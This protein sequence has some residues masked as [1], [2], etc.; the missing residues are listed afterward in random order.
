[1]PEEHDNKFEKYASILNDVGEEGVP[2]AERKGVNSKAYFKFKEL[3]KD[4][5]EDSDS[6]NL[7]LDGLDM[8]FSSDEESGEASEKKEEDTSSSEETEETQ[9]DSDD[10][11]TQTEQDIA[12]LLELPVVKVPTETEDY[13]YDGP[14]IKEVDDKI[15]NQLL[16]DLDQEIDWVDIQQEDRIL[17]NQTQDFLDDGEDI[18]NEYVMENYKE[19]DLKRPKIKERRK[20]IDINALLNDFEDLG[21]ETIDDDDEILDKVDFNENDFKDINLDDTDISDIVEIEE[22]D[23]EE[24]PAEE[25]I[26]E[27][28]VAEEPI[29]EEPVAEDIQLD[30]ISDDDS[31]SLDDISDDDSLSLDDISDDDSLSLDDI[32]DDDSLSL[33]DISDDDSLSLDDISD[34]DSLSLDDIS[35][36]DSLSLDDISD[37]DSLSLD[38]DDLITDDLDEITEDKTEDKTEEIFEDLDSDIELQDISDEIDIDTIDTDTTDTDSTDT[39][40]LEIDI[41][42]TPVTDM[43]DEDS[44]TPADVDADKE[45]EELFPEDE[46]PSLSEDALDSLSEQT[47]EAPEDEMPSLSEDALD[48]LSEQTDEESEDEMPSLSEDALDSLSEQTDEESE[49]EMPSLSEDAL[50]SLSEQT[51]EEPEISM[52]DISMDDISI[53]DDISDE[54]PEDE[55]PSLSEDALDSLSEQTDDTSDDE[56]SEFDLAAEEPTIEEPTI[57]EPSIEEPTIEEPTIEEPSIEEPTIEEPT[58]EEPSIEEP[59]IEEPIISEDD[60]TADLFGDPM[61]DNKEETPKEEDVSES[62]EEILTEEPIEESKDKSDE[63]DSLDDIFADEEP[64][65]DIDSEEEST[66]KDE[67]AAAS[68]SS[69]E[70]FQITE[71]SIQEKQE[72]FEMDIN[73]NISNE[74]EKENESEFQDFFDS[75]DKLSDVDDKK[76]TQEKIDIDTDIE[77][78]NET[79][80]LKLTDKQ[81]QKIVENTQKLPQ[82]LPKIIDK[83]DL[84]QN[85]LN[86]MLLLLLNDPNPQKI[87]DFI[88]KKTKQKIKLKEAPKKKSEKK[89]RGLAIHPALKVAS[90]LFLLVIIFILLYI[91]MIAP[92]MRADKKFEDAYAK[93]TEPNPN[94]I[95]NKTDDVYTYLE[96]ALQEYPRINLGD[97]IYYQKAIAKK[98]ILF[99][100]P[101]EAITVLTG[102][103]D[104]EKKYPNVSKG[105]LFYDPDDREA[106]ILLAKAYTMKNDYEKALTPYGSKGNIIKEQTLPNV[107]PNINP[108][109]NNKKVVVFH[110]KGNEEK[111][112]NDKYLA[113]GA[114]YLDDDDDIEVLHLI[115]KT[116]IKQYDYEL[117][118]NPNNKNKIARIY[119]LLESTY[120]KIAKLEP[121]YYVNDFMKLCLI[122]RDID[123]KMSE[124]K[125]LHKVK[126]QW[127][128][129]QSKY[130]EFRKM[131]AFAL[132]DIAEYYLNYIEKMNIINE[133][134]NRREILDMISN[135]LK[136]IINKK[137]KYPHGIYLMGEVF[138]AMNDKESAKKRYTRAIMLYESFKKIKPDKEIDI[139]MAYVNRNLQARMM[140]GIGETYLYI[141]E[142]L[143]KNDNSRADNMKN[144]RIHFL[145]SQRMDQN[146][147][148]AY[149]NLANM[150]YK[151]PIEEIYKISKLTKENDRSNIREK[152]ELEK[153]DVLELLYELGYQKMLEKGID[154]KDA[155]YIPILYSL[156]VVHY[157]KGVRLINNKDLNKTYE[158]YFREYDTKIY[159]KINIDNSNEIKTGYILNAEDY[160]E[161]AEEYWYKIR[162]NFTLRFLP[163][164]TTAMGNVSY[165]MEDYKGAIRYFKNNV[166]HFEKEREKFIGMRNPIDEYQNHIINQ[167]SNN[168]NNLGVAL[169]SLA[170]QKLNPDIARQAIEKFVLA[171]STKRE[172]N[173]DASS[174][175]SSVLEKAVYVIENNKE[176]VEASLLQFASKK[177]NKRTKRIVRGGVKPRLLTTISYNYK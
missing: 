128:N 37:D 55:M 93:I 19:S 152:R 71:D 68:A 41:D 144:A 69:D 91:G 99:D 77:N 13:K 79:N 22:E 130:Y 107:N 12:D 119:G 50:D 60:I 102:N 24:K 155:R 90:I 18:T 14:V 56:T 137:L 160:F 157:Y 120:D 161:R 48:S 133:D 28:P 141:A 62:T 66:E 35:D 17:E 15:V 6:G 100:K 2:L 25:P 70:D 118:R 158:D 38:D 171:D 53:D 108:K 7:V 82:P 146:Q 121:T 54:A 140:N 74:Q 167:L 164:L 122:I 147:Y 154:E 61:I 40:E 51:D 16:Y 127:D 111:A 78:M 124:E 101:D 65:W 3:D 156:G 117:L 30:D 104:L 1:M 64:T 173:R 109:L 98:F 73:D 5:Q 10:K 36:D 163:N 89:K 20:K 32:S 175:Q 138:N 83:I 136:P 39:E 106:R 142:S 94:K 67:L 23:E 132:V 88:E 123:P 115:G 21:I 134:N 103:N 26:T 135:M 166:E 139:D 145:L 170:Q 31:L 131:E 151:T 168:Y 116:L 75:E 46:M 172:L 87:K 44:L 43:L 81:L 52:D 72:D 150:I 165:L 27:E 4:G 49:D 57:E 47:D 174:I 96:Q 97:D 11:K 105:A 42:E 76:T 126:K 95:S 9:T 176:V 45:T 114:L 143:P 85:E 162:S 169:Y 29:T 148:R 63:E 8:D 86:Q 110:N 177:V 112:N 34:D 129:I 149:I 153:L 125:K 113:L 159:K 92:M 84:P 33:D 80:D 58:I 59:S